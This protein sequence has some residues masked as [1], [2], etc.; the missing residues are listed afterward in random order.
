MKGIL[1]LAYLLTTID[2]HAFTLQG[3]VFESVGNKLNL[4]PILLYSV[5]LEVSSQYMGKGTIAPSP[6]AI[7]SKNNTHYYKDLFIAKKNLAEIVSKTNKVQ[8]GLMQISLNYHPQKYPLKL[9]DPIKNLT[10]GGKILKTSL[11]STTDPVLGV[12]RYFSWNSKI[13]LKKGSHVW[14]TYSRLRALQFESNN[15]H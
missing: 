7:H 10:V 3:T 8:I 14:A 12:G 13:A 9:L 2:A 6:Y 4:D 15:D 1:S 11:S 5:A